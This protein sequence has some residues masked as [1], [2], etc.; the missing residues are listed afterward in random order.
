M[1][2]VIIIGVTYRKQFFL[3]II[4]SFPRGY[5]Y[6]DKEYPLSPSMMLALKKVCAS[7]KKRK[8]FGPKD[9]KR[10]LYPLIERGLIN[11]TYYSINDEKKATWGVT[12]KGLRSLQSIARKQQFA[13]E[14]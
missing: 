13:K 14:S 6:R 3:T 2:I 12:K 4:K 11:L 5:F 7:Q 8:P 9:M 10:A 1:H